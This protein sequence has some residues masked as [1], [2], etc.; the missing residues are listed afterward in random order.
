MKTFDEQFD[1]IL[2]EHFFVA[3]DDIKDSSRFL[4]ELNFELTD[5]V[6][7]II[8]IRNKFQVVIPKHDVKHI[9]T[10]GSAKK[11]IKQKLKINNYIYNN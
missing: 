8:E 3:E 4:V 6:N 11:Y 7:F 1:Q 2:I 5:V 10:V 9:L